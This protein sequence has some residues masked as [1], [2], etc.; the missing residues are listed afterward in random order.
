[1]FSID[2]PTGKVKVAYTGSSYVVI[3]SSSVLRIIGFDNDTSLCLYAAGHAPSPVPNN[4]ATYLANVVAPNM[5]DCYNLSEM[6]IRIKDVEAILS[7]DAVTD[8]ST[9][10]LFNNNS[11]IYTVKQCTDHYIPLLQPQS[12]LQSLKIQLLN[13]EGDLYD[14]VNNEAV[15]LM[16]FYCLP[17]NDGVCT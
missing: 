16:E 2:A 1:M 14:T 12:R 3:K 11:N 7:N 6:I 8:R 17:K 15:F 13:M 4:T 5:Y 10:V 9:A